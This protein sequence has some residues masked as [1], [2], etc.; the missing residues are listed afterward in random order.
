MNLVDHSTVLST[1]GMTCAAIAIMI[2]RG[3]K[4]TLAACN[5]R[6]AGPFRKLL[7]QMARP[8]T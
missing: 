6:L 8:S 7:M 5:A 4:S 2:A 1:D 3:Q